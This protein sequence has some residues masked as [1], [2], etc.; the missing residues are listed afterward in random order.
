MILS[1]A[2]EIEEEYK[3]RMD[4]RAVYCDACEIYFSRH[5]GFRLYKVNAGHQ[6]YSWKGDVLP[7]GWWNFACK[8]GK[9]FPAIE[10]EGIECTCNKCLKKEESNNV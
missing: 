6:V 1:N 4:A 9:E 5:D 2:V 10:F 8:C 3:K 7:G